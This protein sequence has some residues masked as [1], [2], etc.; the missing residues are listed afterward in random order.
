MRLSLLGLTFVASLI[1]ANSAPVSVIG[2]ASAQG[3]DNHGVGF[4]PRPPLSPIFPPIAVV[5][6]ST[7]NTDGTPVPCQLT[8]AK[9]QGV[10]ATSAPSAANK[11]RF[12][13]L[14]R[15][16]IERCNA[17]DDVRANA[18]LAEALGMVER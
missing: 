15:R 1:F 8:L 9:M 18:F 16:G 12:D 4:S 7:L 5:R 13:D 2:S 10:L 14:R 11:A 17:N 3:Q 6:F